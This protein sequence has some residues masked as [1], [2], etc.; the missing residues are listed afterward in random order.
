LSRLTI[1]T[2]ETLIAEVREITKD[3]IE[4][5]SVM[6]PGVEG[7]AGTLRIRHHKIAQLIAGGLKQ[8][9]VAEILNCTQANISTLLASPSM[10]S[11]VREY[12]LSGW[13]EIEAVTRRARL[14]AS[15]GVEELHRRFEQAPKNIA[16]KDLTSATLGL[17]DRGG[18]AQRHAHVHFGLSTQDIAELL[19]EASANDDSRVVDVAAEGQGSSVR[20]VP[21]LGALSGS[22]PGDDSGSEGWVE[23]RAES[24]AAS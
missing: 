21:R 8:V 2:T 22:D 10:Q 20:R 16:T 15:S 9:E 13:A 4:A 11:L 23:V 1:H 19:K 14:A 17:L 12:L 18:I 5:L 3:D 6:G 7:S 24:Q